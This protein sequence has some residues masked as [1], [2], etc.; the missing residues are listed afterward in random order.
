M[1]P[2][3]IKE[4]SKESLRSL[5]RAVTGAALGFAELEDMLAEVELDRT[6][7]RASTWVGSIGYERFKDVDE[8]VALLR[9]E[10]VELLIDVRELPISR[11]RGYAKT[12]LREALE[13]GG[14]EYLHMKG[15]GNPKEIRDLYKSGSVDEGRRLYGDNVRREQDG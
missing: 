14:I 7:G 15:L 8:F 10:G 1:A 5:T 6:G 9:K 2:P 4:A 13:S 12:A 3:A 11:R